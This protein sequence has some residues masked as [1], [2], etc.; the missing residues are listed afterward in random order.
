MPFILSLSFCRAGS[1]PFSPSPSL[2]RT[3]QTAILVCS[4]CSPA[5]ARVCVTLFPHGYDWGGPHRDPSSPVSFSPVPFFPASCSSLCSCPQRIG[6]GWLLCPVQV[7][8]VGERGRGGCGC[9]PSR[10]GRLFSLGSPTCGRSWPTWVSQ[11]LL[12][13][14]TFVAECYYS[15]CG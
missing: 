4:S 13:Y 1:H 10:R 2:S 5:V 3:T 14:R 7:S 8:R 12:G 11:S 15:L 6:E 9:L